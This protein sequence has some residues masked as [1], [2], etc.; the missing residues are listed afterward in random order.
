M[1]GQSIIEAINKIK[2]DCKYNEL[3]ESI[4]GTVTYIDVDKF[5]QRVMGLVYLV[6]TVNK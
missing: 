1:E 6:E 3:D 2:E 4:Q 5:Y